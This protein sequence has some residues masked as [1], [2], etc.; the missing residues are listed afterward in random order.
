MAKKKY[1]TWTLERH[2][3]ATREVTWQA[4]LDFIPKATGGYVVEGDPAPHGAG[5]IVHLS[6]DGYDMVETVL[7]LEA[8]WRRVYEL[9]SGSPVAFYQATTTIRDDGDSSIGVCVNNC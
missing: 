6:I 1:E 8:P 5:A 9:T 3:D 7:S 2:V 4:L